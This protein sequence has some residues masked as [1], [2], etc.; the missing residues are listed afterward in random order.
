MSKITNYVGIDAVIAD[1]VALE[2]QQPVIVKSWN[3]HDAADAAR[4]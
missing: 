1:T 4:C 3:P 2:T